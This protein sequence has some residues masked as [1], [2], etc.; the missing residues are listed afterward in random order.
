[1]AEGECDTQEP[2]PGAR[3]RRG[4]HGAAAPTE[5]QPESPDELRRELARKRHGSLPYPSW[6]RHGGRAQ[7]AAFV[8]AA[9]RSFE[10]EPQ[11][12]MELIAC[13]KGTSSACTR[14]RTRM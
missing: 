14:S 7:P 13:V 1:E 12:E 3:K 10:P 4:Q 8:I 11:R 6:K 9:T 5:D 2:D